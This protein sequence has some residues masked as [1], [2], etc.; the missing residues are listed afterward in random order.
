MTRKYDLNEAPLKSKT[1][2]AYDNSKEKHPPMVLK[3]VTISNDY[4]ILFVIYNGGDE[5]DLRLEHFSPSS[6][7]L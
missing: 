6:G 1:K 5:D 2:F 3:T 4:E 7:L